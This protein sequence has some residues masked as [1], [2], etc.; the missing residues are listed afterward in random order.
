MKYRLKLLFGFLVIIAI[1]IWAGAFNSYQ[2]D[3]TKD[4]KVYFLNVGQGDA[5]YIKTPSGQDILIDGGSNNSVLT[6]LGRVMDLGDRKIDLVVLTHPH[7]DHLTGLIDVINRFEIN[8]VWE[9]GVEYPSATY[10]EWKK[11]IK[12][13]GISNRFVTAGQEKWFG[14]VKFF[15]LTPLSSLKNEKIDNL[16]NASIVSELE[17]GQFS[18][19]FLGDAES[20]QAQ[21]LTKVKPTTVVKIAHHG[22]K[23]ALSEELM[24]IIRPSIAVIEVGAKNNFG[25]PAPSVIDYLKS[26]AAQIYRTDQNGTINISSDGLNWSVNK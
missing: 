15:V 8:E 12:E 1:V 17:F 14:S 20:I 10:D 4:L 18:A 25:H 16:N 13:K 23:N 19:L 3:S 24:N 5:E 22:S 21:I 9:T 11:I 2:A 7:A 6:E 26:I